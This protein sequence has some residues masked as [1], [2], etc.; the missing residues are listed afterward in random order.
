[1]SSLKGEIEYWCNVKGYGLVKYNNKQAF[2]HS[3]NCTREKGKWVSFD[4]GDLVSFEVEDNVAKKVKKIAGNI[5]PDAISSPNAD[6][7]GGKV[8][9]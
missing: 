5:T 3:I 1:M 4:R 2:V 8:D 6:T 7:P 9:E